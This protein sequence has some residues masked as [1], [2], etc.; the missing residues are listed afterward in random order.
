MPVIVE[1][2]NN[3]HLASIFVFILEWYRRSS[4]IAQVRDH[5]D[6]E[7]SVSSLN[8]MSVPNPLLKDFLE[9]KNR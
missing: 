9:L 1:N 7:G 2:F 6:T 3:R 8:R 5:L 4:Q